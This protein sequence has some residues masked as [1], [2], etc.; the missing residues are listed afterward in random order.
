MGLSNMQNRRSGF[1]LVELL[2]VI[3]IIGILVGLLL[4]AVQA[5]REA[6]RRMSCS[7]NM[8]QIGLSMH[9]YHDTHKVFSPFVIRNGQGDYWRG[10]SAFSQVL[11]FIEQGN[12]YN[13]LTTTTNSFYANW[14]EGG[15][16]APVR[17]TSISAFLCPSA[18]RF[19]SSGTGWAN[20]PGCNYGVSFG[21][22]IAWANYKN[23]NGMFRGQSDANAKT[24]TRMGDVS[25][26]LSNTLLA[27][28]HL[29]GDDNNSFLMTGQSSEPRIGSGFP[30]GT[31][32][33]PSQEELDQ[34]GAACASQ[35][36]HNSTNGG[37][38]LSPEP[39]QTALNTAAP[40]NW[41]FPNCQTSGS[42]FASD[43][44]GIYTARSMHTGGVQCATGDGSVRFVSGSIDLLT[45]QY[46]GARNDGQSLQM[47][48]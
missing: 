42:G 35:T 37:Q 11:P 8:K 46:Y 1:T 45:W 40:P 25:D 33:Y 32:Q 31:I 24:S 6:A 3:A 43:R 26:G 38:W 15:P 13:Q 19:P 2:V 5:A 48:E 23:Q 41:K 21:T 27:S 12:L 14:D 44:D 17:A 30:N 10:Y 22:T 7:N 20:G 36:A 4:P 16:H 28:E 9:N 34:F 47:P 39:T 18:P 29:S